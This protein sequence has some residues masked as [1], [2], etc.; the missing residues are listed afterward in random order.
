MPPAAPS[1][2]DGVPSQGI[3]PSTGQPFVKR[4]KDAT[5]VQPAAAYLPYDTLFSRLITHAPSR[6]SNNGTVSL[7]VERPDLN[8]RVIV[9]QAEFSILHGMHGSGWEEQPGR[10]HADQICVMGTSAIRIVCDTEERRTWAEAGDQMFFDLDLGEQNLAVGD[11]VA[12]GEVQDDE[13]VV[14]EVTSKLHKGC[15]KFSKRFGK[16]ALAVVN[17]PQGRRMRLRGIYFRVVRGGIVR[18]GDAIVKVGG[19]FGG[20]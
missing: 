7:L 15:P 4:S 2:A 9:P 6:P 18:E 12:L 19:D 16:D 11:R 1:V 14:L 10:G 3:S 5:P 13:G 8:E 20:Q 17:C